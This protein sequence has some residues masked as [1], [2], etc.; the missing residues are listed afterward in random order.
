[1]TFN[2]AHWVFAFSYLVLSYRI[3]LIKNNLPVETYSRQINTA[4]ILVCAFNVIVPVIAWLFSALYDDKAS[5]ITDCIWQASLVMSCIVLVWGIY[6]MVRFFGSYNDMLPNKVIII[7]H[8][9]AYLFVI[10]TNVVQGFFS[11]NLRTYKISII[12][13]FVVYFVCTLIFGLIVNTIVVKIE[14]ATKSTGSPIS[15]LSNTQT[16]SPA[17]TQ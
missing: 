7:M 10:I 17:G 8:I 4:N 15:S 11:Y 3:E 12:C 16:L 9:V 2:L 6:R 1:M 13:A 5:F 14:I